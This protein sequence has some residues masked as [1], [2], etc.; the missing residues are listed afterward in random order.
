MHSDL[1]L[2]TYGS[3]FKMLTFKEKT[4]DFKVINKI[5]SNQYEI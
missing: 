5:D 4:S 2:F 3:E 1:P